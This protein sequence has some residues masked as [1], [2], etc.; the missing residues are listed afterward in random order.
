MLTETADEAPRRRYLLT[1]PGDTRPS[2]L[3]ELCPRVDEDVL[4]EAREAMFGLGCGNGLVLDA[5]Q[6]VILHDTFKS[7]D[8][9]SIEQEPAR[10]ETPRLLGIGDGP[11]EQR[12][13]RW[14]NALATNWHDTVPHEAWVAPLL[15]DVVPAASG[16]LIRRA[17]VGSTR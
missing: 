5:K 9:G 10:L 2:L 7:M 13:E 4:R 3:V 15:T 1:P 16:S 11:I 17:M 12:L 14:L 6:C 8:S